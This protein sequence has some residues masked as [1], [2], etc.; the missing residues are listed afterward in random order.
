MSSLRETYAGAGLDVEMAIN[1]VRSF[2]ARH[3]PAARC[4]RHAAVVKRAWR[5]LDCWD[6][7]DRA[8]RLRGA[9]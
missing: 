1:E 8:M 2:G 7:A 4:R 5:V 9:L 6:H 3:P